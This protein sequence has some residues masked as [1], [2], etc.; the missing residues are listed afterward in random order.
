MAGVGT[1]DALQPITYGY[2]G[3]A[4]V[5]NTDVQADRCAGYRLIHDRSG[6][7]KQGWGAVLSKHMPQPARRPTPAEG[8]V[9]RAGLAQAKRDARWMVDAVGKDDLLEMARGGMALIDDLR[10]LWLSR[11][12]RE[13]EWAAVVNFLQGVL[14]QKALESLTQA[15]CSAIKTIVDAYVAGGAVRDGDV[16]IVVRMLRHVGFDPYRAISCAEE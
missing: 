7:P 1:G 3:Q 8:S 13:D 12:A 14:N 15:Q 4:F 16:Q 11:A 6:A 9:L 10:S 2:E 5:P